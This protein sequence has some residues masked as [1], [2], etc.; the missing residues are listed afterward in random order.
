M[1]EISRHAVLTR[2]AVLAFGST[3]PDHARPDSALLRFGA[4]P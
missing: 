2:R 1:I 3:V 4:Q